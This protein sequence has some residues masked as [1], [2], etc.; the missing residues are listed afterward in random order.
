V[1]TWTDAHEGAE[2]AYTVVLDEALRDKHDPI[3]LLQ[4]ERPHRMV[5]EQ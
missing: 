5:W 1:I 4:G 2:H 3:E